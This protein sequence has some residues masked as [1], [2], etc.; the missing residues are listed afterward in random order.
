MAGDLRFWEAAAATH[1]DAPQAGLKRLLLLLDE[2]EPAWAAIDALLHER[3]DGME[4]WKVWQRCL[5]ALHASAPKRVHAER[6]AGRLV[7]DQPAHAE[8]RAAGWE[9]WPELLG[10]LVRMWGPT[11]ADGG[12]T[13]KG[14]VCSACGA[15]AVWGATACSCGAPVNP[16]RTRMTWERLHE[17]GLQAGQPVRCHI[18]VH[19]TNPTWHRVK[20][21]SWREGLRAPPKRGPVGIE[22]A[23]GVS[24]ED[25]FG[26]TSEGATT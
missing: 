7:A 19:P 16:G 13:E 15:K 21:A 18:E 24:A 11:K 4:R 3:V 9:P 23:L 1:D 14:P 8:L 20:W 22:E 17:G 25:V 2:P 5:T 6:V 10:R 12:V 26:K